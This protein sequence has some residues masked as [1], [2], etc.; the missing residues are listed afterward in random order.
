MSFYVSLCYP[1]KLDVSYFLFKLGQLFIIC[2]NFQREE[3]SDVSWDFGEFSW[4]RE[5]P[6]PNQ[7]VE[8]KMRQTEASVREDVLSEQSDYRWHGEDAADGIMPICF[9]ANRESLCD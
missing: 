8:R 7:S 2:K 5:K 3:T 4:K 1:S 9:A 6:A